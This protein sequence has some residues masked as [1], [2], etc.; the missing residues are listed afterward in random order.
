MAASLNFAAFSPTTYADVLGRSPVMSLGIREMWPGIPRLA[1]PAF[2]V[3]CPPGDNLM[4][5]AAIY[6]AAP[7][8]VIVVQAGDVEY[9][10]S[11]GNVCAI[12]QQR[13]IAGFVADGVIRDVAEVREAQFP[14]FARGVVP[15]PGKKQTLG[16]LNQPIICGGVAV[17]PRDIVVADEEGIVVI[18]AA[19]QQTVWEQAQQKS[20]REANQT[21]AEWEANHHAKIEGILKDLGF[22]P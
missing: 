9:A 4:L 11:G 3:Q 7:G 21:L 19:Q 8:D 5:H 6:R 2:T 15:I 10:L 18:P 20:D 14:V 13:G 1:G 12:A 22:Q 17:S 16:T